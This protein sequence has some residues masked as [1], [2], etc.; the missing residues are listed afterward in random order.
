LTG[1][2]E[3]GEWRVGNEKMK[4][5]CASTEGIERFSAKE[6]FGKKT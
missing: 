6:N 1:S 4:H 3:K 2:K 5:F